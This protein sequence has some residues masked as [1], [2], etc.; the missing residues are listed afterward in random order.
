MYL[1]SSSINEPESETGQTNKAP[2]NETK[3]EQTTCLFIQ[4]ELCKRDTL[5]DWLTDHIKN[6]PRKKVL[7]F[8]K[9]VCNNNNINRDDIIYCM[10]T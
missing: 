4:T 1:Y 3:Q 2:I 7:Q 8:I 5:R 9:Q 6:R 10:H